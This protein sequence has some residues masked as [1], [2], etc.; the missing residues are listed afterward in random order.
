MNDLFSPPKLA[1]TGSVLVHFDGG[2]PCN[3]PRLGYGIGYGSYNFDG[4][5]PIRVSF[6]I[7]CSANTAEL[8]TLAAALMDLGNKIDPKTCAVHVI[9]DSQIALKWLRVAA[10]DIRGGL[11][12]KVAKISV[13][14]SPDFKL[15]IHKLKQAAEPFAHLTG[16]WKG[17]AHAVAAFGH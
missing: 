13:G 4:G 8:L 12:K 17:R 15:A 11:K 16:E 10:G 1:P 7:H 9:G 5:E 2:T 14:S 6:G 3:I